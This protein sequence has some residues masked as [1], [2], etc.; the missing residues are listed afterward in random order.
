[1]M[2]EANRDAASTVVGAGARPSEVF[3]LVV[4]R[5]SK[6][7]DV[8]GKIVPV[9]GDLSLSLDK[10]EIVSIVGPSGCGKTTLLNTLCG[11]IAPDAGRIR[12]YGR[13]LAGQPQNVGYMLQ[14]DLLLPW[15]T[16]LGNVMLGLEIRGVSASEAHDRSRYEV[17]LF[18]AG[19]DDGTPLR[20]RM[21]AASEHFVELHGQDTA[22]MAAAI[23][24][25][26]IDILVDVKG[27][28]YGSVMQVMAHRPAP[29]QVNWL[30][31][32][33]TSGADYIDYLIG[34]P[35]VT[36]LAHAEHFSERIAQL[37]LCY[38]PND[39]RRALPAVPPRA[40]LGLPERALVL[41]AFHQSY[42]ISQP[43][44]E[45]WCRLLLALPDAVLW[46]LRWNANVQAALTQAALQRGIDLD[47]LVF[48]PCLPPEQHLAR[49][50]AA[51][52]FLDTW[53][54]NAHTTASEAL[55]VG[56]PPVTLI[57][58]TFAQRVAA[59]LLHASG[60]PELVCGDVAHYERTVTQLAAQPALR[61][62]LHARLT[63]Q[64]ATHRVFD[65]ARFA[66]D[67]EALF[68][69]MRARALAGLPPD[70]LPAQDTA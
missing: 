42:K 64:R 62:Q 23:R 7:Y 65:G 13:E 56:V 48:A 61:E 53:P 39:N 66:R 25:R 46:L 9:I 28:T 15:R 1:M 49:L 3:P 35:I 36:P 2:S 26:A 32:P 12:W 19:P 44:F 14:K 59:S 52:V 33:G 24:E 70:H 8:D 38:Q 45:A 63:A 37:P 68:Q 54:C 30:G 41:C 21:R 6:S 11:L 47:R 5:V 51:D 57:G 50:G 20:Q 34:D 58:E 10:G 43:V 17:T 40:Q 4:D 29:L 18:S 27:A 31:F 67:I 16:A 22:A 69:R 55:W 60:T